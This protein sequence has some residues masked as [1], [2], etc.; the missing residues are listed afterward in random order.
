MGK[1]RKKNLFVVRENEINKEKIEVS[2]KD[3]YGRD[4]KFFNLGFL[5]LGFYGLVIN[6]LFILKLV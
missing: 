2:K 3:K 4:I 6:V 5:G 1:R